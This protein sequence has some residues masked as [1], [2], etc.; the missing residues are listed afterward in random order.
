[1]AEFEIRRKDGTTFQVQVDDADL[2]SVRVAGPWHVWTDGKRRTM[3]VLR[4]AP[5][6]EHIRL[7]R[8]LT[9]AAPGV[10]VDHRDGNGLNNQRENLRE[11][12]RSENLGNRQRNRNNQTGL[13]GIY[14]DKK[15]GLYRAEI[16]VRGE[17]KH[18]GRFD[19]PEAAHRAYC[20]A[21][22][23]LFG[24]FARFE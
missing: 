20:L 16:Q 19:S 18:L 22:R 3:Y 13:K 4:N 17:R 21:A 2:E 14:L 11:A 1:V 8:F 10:S 15:S 6:G 23:E 24:K 7:H 12:S 5:S 9:D